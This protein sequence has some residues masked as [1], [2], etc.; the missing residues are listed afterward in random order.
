MVLDVT[1][2]PFLGNSSFDAA[3]NLTAAMN[4]TSLID[5]SLAANVTNATKTA[6]NAIAEIVGGG[7]GRT[8]EGIIVPDLGTEEVHRIW[9][10]FACVLVP[11]IAFEALVFYAILDGGKRL[12]TTSEPP[13]TP[14]DGGRG[15]AIELRPREM[16]M[17]TTSS[18]PGDEEEAQVSGTSSSS[19][20]S[21]VSTSPAMPS[22]ERGDAVSISITSDQV[23]LNTVA[24]SSSTNATEGLLPRR[25]NALEGLRVIGAIHVVLFHFYT[26]SNQQNQ[27]L[28][29]KLGTYW[30]HIFY[31]ITGLVSY[32]SC[33]RSGTA[34]GGLRLLEKRL[35]TFYPLVFIS[36]AITYFSKA[37]VNVWVTSITTQ[38]AL[39]LVST[40][41]P[42]FSDVGR[43]NGPAWFIGSLTLY[44]IALP[45]W[46]VAAKRASGQVL[47]AMTFIVYLATFAPHLA[48]YGLL[49]LDSSRSPGTYI[50]SGM[51]TFSPYTNW[52]HVPAG[53]CLAAALDRF[54]FGKARDFLERV[55]ASAGSLAVA[56]FIS[57]YRQKHRHTLDLY[58][59]LING[60]FSYP[61]LAVLLIGCTQ[62]RDPAA[63]VLRFIGNWGKYSLPLYL[64]HFPID[65]FLRTAADCPSCV[66]EGQYYDFLLLPV[67]LIIGTYLGAVFQDRWNAYIAPKKRQ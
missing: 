5:G 9:V 53:V 15:K 24:S 38:R 40:F 67:C 36:Y 60:P 62:E 19:E 17:T 46:C 39:F 59:M 41:T 3:M 54:R 66:K 56:V 47:A 65:D 23:V 63:R 13:R 8:V 55:G 27:C 29:C 20:P 35:K 57:L 49:G 7:G 12:A 43:L 42:P 44:W 32:R 64:L 10:M 37:S 33:A 58:R 25:M 45:H 1:V 16:T 14:D 28:P 52:M 31:I 2:P 22:P 61:V 11:F 6:T 30:V 34:T 48:W 4:A 51:V 50:V 21:P 26:F 18:K